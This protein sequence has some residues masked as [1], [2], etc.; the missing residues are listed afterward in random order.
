[1]AAVTAD[2]ITAG[3][4]GERLTAVRER[5]RSSGRDPGDITIVGVTKGHGPEACEAALANGIADLGESYAQ[6]LR[7]KAAAIEP[8][9]S[10]APPRWHFIG[11]IQRR[12]V[13]LLA[14]LVDLWQSVDRVE[15]L[16]QIAA[17]A[18]G[19]QVLVQV[20]VSAEPGKAG[21]REEEVAP[22]V[23]HA[24][25]AGL[26]VR[27][28]MAVGPTTGGP[29][30]ARPGFRRVAGLRR[31]LGLRELSLGM[32]GDLRVALEEGTTMVRLGTVLFGPRPGRA[33][34]GAWNDR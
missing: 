12:K 26:E 27:G 20:S 18:P 23:E 4:V 31:E 3:E 19:A 7:S 6:E 16:D 17:R 25:S 11:G 32:S 1:M 34:V 9:S 14:P 10:M 30:A 13:R 29:E 5:I 21:C 28:L 33:P 2:R 15:V 8:T 24:R 22:L